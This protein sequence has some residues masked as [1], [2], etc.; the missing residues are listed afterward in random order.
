MHCDVDLMEK[1]YIL[2]LDIKSICLSPEEEAARRGELRNIGWRLFFR[3][4]K[5]AMLVHKYVFDVLIMKL[6]SHIPF[7]EGSEKCRFLENCWDR[8][9]TWVN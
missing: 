8:I 5:H 9:G 7:N 6:C 3:G 2:V 4:S 1:T